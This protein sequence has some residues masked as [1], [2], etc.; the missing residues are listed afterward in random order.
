MSLTRLDV[1]RPAQNPE[2]AEKVIRKLN[3]GLMPPPGAPRPDPAT[4]KSVA[5]ALAAGIDQ[6]A[7]THPHPGRP[8]LHRLNR[9]EYANAVR[10]LLNVP[11][12]AT[13][14]LPPDAM[15]HGFDNMADVLTTSPALMDAYVRAASNISRLA[16]G[17][18]EVHSTVVKFS[19]PKELSQAKHV[20]GAPVGTRG[21]ISVIHQFPA[22]G[23]YV[24]QLSFYHSLDGP[25]FGKIL[26][27][28]QQIEVSLDGARVSLFDID[29]KMTKW[30]EIKTPPTRIPAGPHR[31]SAAFIEKFEGPVE[32]AVMAVEEPLVDLNEA[33]VAGL[34]PL[35]HLNDLSI[36]GPAHVTGVGDT[37]SRR[38]IFTCR[39]A[40]S[41]DEAAC[42]KKILAALLR[43]AFRRP[44][45]DADLEDAMGLYQ[46]GRNAGDFDA[47][48]R[49]AI[50]GILASPL[51]VFRFER[52]PANTVPGTVY[53]LGDL[54]LAS[55][56]SF[57]LWSS[58]PDE[59]L[60]ALAAQGKLNTPAMLEKQVRRMLADPRAETLSTNFARQWLHLQ[61]LKDLQPDAYQFPNYSR[62][63]SDSMLRETELFFQS[64]MRE[65]RSVQE[66]L[67][68]DY[69]YVDELLAQHYGIP[70]VSGS[71]FRRV[72][73]PDQNRRGL[74]GH[75]SILTLTSVSN[76][77]SPVGRGKYVMEVLLGTPPPPPPPNVPALKENTAS[78]DAQILSVRQ[79]MEQHR[80]N[81]PCA[82]CHKLMDPIGFALE[83]FDAVGAW[84]TLD[85]GRSIDASGKM[86]DGA[87][88]N[89]PVS[90]REAVLS[91]SDAF[92]TSFT[93][94]LL[95]YGA[96]RVLDSSDMPAVRSIAAGAAVNGD[97]FSAFIL[98]VV[99]S[100]P[101]QMSAVEASPAGGKASH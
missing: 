85:G 3:L 59:E 47:G 81:E 32:D 54:E 7:T 73:I 86:F 24:F 28:G 63:L 30:D 87:I 56:L 9:T 31:V 17:D 62:N 55:R 11:V 2:L 61:N 14:L 52:P 38:K 84:R 57:F 78:G 90:L 97:K 70:S 40:V 25:L 46:A 60:I 68:A 75:A 76:R 20:Q 49:L 33:D 71:A 83:N 101:F 53:R 22:D 5:T 58:L 29:P 45:T 48:I 99:K 16:V 42:A 95:A 35:P 77:T 23:E 1:S 41:R 74:L 100:A 65:D 6:A 89:G 98:G 91:H 82:T 64:I 88:L 96:G 10:D 15:S 8:P 50:Q 66:L 44:V 43:Q 4:L 12:D 93:E 36:A 34:T 51:F 19:L 27:K 80:E 26:G 79:Q 21:G 94:S 18:P 13:A 69:T 67:T 72:Q 39:A 92:I 37:P